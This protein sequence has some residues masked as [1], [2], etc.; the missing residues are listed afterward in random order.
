MEIP[1]GY[2]VELD[3]N[4]AQRTA[5]L[6]H[7]GAA[8]FVWNWG[9]SRRIQEYEE[10]GKSSSAFDQQ[11]QLSSIK[12]DQFLWMYEVSSTA[13]NSSL[14][15]L[16]QAYQSFF[17]R[18]KNGDKK[19]GFPKF[20]SRKRGV[21][22]F[23]LY[24]SIHVENSRIKLPRIGWVRLKESG[25]IPVDDECVVSATVSEKAGHWFVSVQVREEIE[26]TQAKGEPIGVD[27]G[28]KTM[29]AVSDK[30]EFKNPKALQNAQRKLA[31]LQRELS[32][33]NRGGKNYEKTK[34]KLVRLHYHIANIRGDAIHKATSAIC[35]TTKQ[36]EER[37]EVI[38]IEDLNVS[39]MV[40]NHCLARA[41]S[42]VGMGEFRRQIEYKALW[43]GERVFVA[44]R[45][46]PS[47]RLCPNCGNV[48][49][50]LTLSDRVWTCECG[51]V[52]DRD[53]NAACN[54]RDLS[55]KT[56]VSST[57]SHACGENVRPIESSWRSQ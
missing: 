23:R 49:A 41:V 25:Y 15:N 52:H 43:N 2:K 10:T 34:K 48:N 56:T 11:K 13:I 18:V 45:F 28:V 36:S 53:F 4:N 8:R 55:I 29:A 22:S 51:A 7:A 42:D 3:P 24:G 6:R 47:S 44:D 50:Q 38:A 54:L 30:R 40:K 33:R 57:E 5:F 46:F 14:R 32:R 9:L 19:A 31:R 37:P 17:R 16:D 21:G 12:R 39:G 27:L 20:K 1:K 35:A 26:V